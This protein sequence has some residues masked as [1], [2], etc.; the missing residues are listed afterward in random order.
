MPSN[1][2]ATATANSSGSQTP[3]QLILEEEEPLNIQGSLVSIAYNYVKRKNVF[4]VTTGNGSE[5]LFQVRVML[6]F[7]AEAF[8]S[9][10]P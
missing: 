2:Q 1:G 7:F 8:R 5:Y 9:F 6:F 4:K 3:S 10:V